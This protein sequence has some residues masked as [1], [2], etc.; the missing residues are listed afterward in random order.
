MTKYVLFLLL[1]FALATSTHAQSN[2]G[3]PSQSGIFQTPNPPTCSSSMTTLPNTIVGTTTDR[4][5]NKNTSTYYA[6]FPSS[7]TGNGQ[8]HCPLIGI[9][10]DCYAVLA[11]NDT[12]AT[13]P[14][15]YNRFYLQA[16][17]VTYISNNTCQ[18][19]GTFQQ[20]F[21]QCLGVACSVCP[22]CPRQ[23]VCTSGC[24]SPIVLDITGTGFVLT[25][26]ENGVKFDI[27]GSGT[28]E[29]IGWTAPG[30]NNAF[31]ALPGADSLVHNGKQLFGNFTPQPSSPNPNGFLALAV[32][33]DPKNGGNGDGVIDSRDAIFSSLRLW[34]DANHDGICQ[35][36]ELHTLPSLGVNSL[37][38]KYKEA[39]KTD[40]YGNEFRYKALVDPDHPNATPIGRVAYDVFFV[41]LAPSVATNA[42][43]AAPSLIK[44]ETPSGMLSKR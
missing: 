38:L 43:C 8:T 31:L 42:K 17:N 21:Q 40:Q 41:T 44:G 16:Y 7:V 1:L 12:V 6:S 25:S 28:A 36:G 11:E 18:Q 10:F 23:K 34:I 5:Y 2:C 33:D 27:M 30:S 39:D 14:T 9:P 26:A 20:D 35:P 37:S 3:I 24:S 4:C 29:Q 13:S 22:Q 19:V 15:D 32:Y